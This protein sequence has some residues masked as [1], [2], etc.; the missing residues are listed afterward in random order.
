MNKVVDFNN[1]ALDIYVRMNVIEIPFHQNN[2][3]MCENY[4][5]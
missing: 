2:K 1:T 5:K 3:C 4:Q